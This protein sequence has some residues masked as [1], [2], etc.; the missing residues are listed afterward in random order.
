MSSKYI[1]LKQIGKGEF[2]ITKRPR[3]LEFYILFD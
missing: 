1:V 2:G 3:L